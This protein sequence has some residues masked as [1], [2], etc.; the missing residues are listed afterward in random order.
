MADAKDKDLNFF[1][2]YNIRSEMENLE[3]ETK[4]IPEGYHTATPYL[5][6]NDVARAIDFYKQAFGATELMRM[7]GPAGR[8]MHA[9]VKIGDSI[10]ML[11][12]ENPQMGVRGPQ[13]L[14]GSPA[15]LYL[16]VEDCDQAFNRAVEAGANATVPLRDQFW[17]D[18]SG[19]VKDP[20]G[21]SWWIATRKEEVSEDEIRRRMAA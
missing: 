16:Y 17:G 9:E 2:T 18:R 1:D 15:F 10:I 19:N 6:V 13:S 7:A 21:H 20:F 12:G 3:A 5:I 11:G 8:I 4:P 14:G